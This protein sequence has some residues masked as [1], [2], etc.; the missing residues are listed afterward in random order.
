MKVRRVDSLSPQH[1]RFT[2]GLLYADAHPTTFAVLANLWSVWPHDEVQLYITKCRY[3][4]WCIVVLIQRVALGKKKKKTFCFL[5]T[6]VTEN[7]LRQV[8]FFRC[9]TYFHDECIQPTYHWYGC[10]WWSSVLPEQR[11]AAWFVLTMLILVCVVAQRPH[12]R[13]TL[14]KFEIVQCKAHH[15]LA[16]IY[17]YVSKGGTIVGWQLGSAKAVLRCAFASQD[18]GVYNSNV[19]VS[20]TTLAYRWCC[21]LWEASGIHSQSRHYKWVCHP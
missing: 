8:F 20:P 12:Q 7:L 15:S 14:K 21:F 6:C 19:S 3:H 5:S 2:I 17:S 16:D 18:W 11:H 4:T 10:R 13:E 9:S 1:S